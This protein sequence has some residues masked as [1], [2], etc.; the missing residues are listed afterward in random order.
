MRL[1]KKN[2]ESNH[3]DS[4]LIDSEFTPTP[5]T[6]AETRNIRENDMIID[7]KPIKNATTVKKPNFRPAKNHELNVK[8]I[9]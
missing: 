3:E 4:M 1:I 7:S 5:T 9:L 8:T 2:M 6:S